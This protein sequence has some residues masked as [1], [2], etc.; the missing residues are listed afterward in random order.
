MKAKGYKTSSTERTSVLNASDGV[1]LYQQ[2]FVILQNKILSGELVPGDLVASE[3]ELCEEFG[4]SRITARRALNELANRG[5][6]DRKRGRGTRV[7]RSPTQPVRASIDGLLE[8]VGRMGRSTT[9]QV[10]RSGTVPAGRETAQALEIEP[11]APVV[12]A[13][14]VRHLGGE[15][16]SYLVTSVPADIGERISGQ[17]MSQVPLLLLLEKAGVPVATARQTITATVADAEVSAALNVPAGAPLIEVRRIVFDTDARAV[18]YI[19]IL[20]R[21]ELYQ[22]E[23]TMHR[24][25]GDKGKVW[26]AQDAVTVEGPDTLQ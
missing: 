15:P 1:P 3:Q 24:R 23:M 5:L 22:F 26:H 11:D 21:P 12:R 19:K 8:N 6:V 10:L 25:S 4:V 7:A 2:I 18:E 20:Y 16:M 9:V 14:R 13:V 17:D